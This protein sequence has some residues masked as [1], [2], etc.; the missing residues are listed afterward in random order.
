MK[1]T[2]TLLLALFISL[3]MLS[4]DIK[5]DIKDNQKL[6]LTYSGKLGAKK[7]FQAY[8]IKNLDNKKFELFS[9][10]INDGNVISLEKIIFD[11][12][13]S[14]ISY[15]LNNNTISML[16]KEER[17]GSGQNLRVLDINTKT[18]EY[19]IKEM[20]RFDPEKTILTLKDKTIIFY[21]ENMKLFFNLIIDSQ[22]ITNKYLEIDKDTRKTFFNEEHITAIN[23]DDFVKNGS[24]QNN[25]L[26]FNNNTIYFTNLN[27]K[28]K[29]TSV[30]C[31]NFDNL[32][33]FKTIIIKN[34]AFENIKD[35][36]SYIF[37]DNIITV[38]CSKNDAEIKITNLNNKKTNFRIFLRKDLSKLLDSKMLYNFIKTSVK[39]KFK[40]TVTVNL[41]VDN[42][43]V[44]NLDFIEKTQYY[45]NNN[46][47]LHWMMQHQMM[48]HQMM[49]QQQMMQR[50]FGP[51]AQEFYLPLFK[52]KENTLIQ[53]VISNDYKI[54]K[55]ASTK[56]KYKNIDIESYMED[57][58]E[59]KSK[60][61]LTALF[62]DDNY[63]IIYYKRNIKT[64]FL[65]KL[66]YDL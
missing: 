10:F 13:I 21:K 3:N 56:T 32:E 43:L 49:I 61:L 27:K 40:P 45:Y 53:F 62:N 18:Q 6:V 7:G 46:W 17:R 26:Y 5:I 4:N 14:I 23:S 52:E 50:N 29:T 58:K 30:L 55:N 59:D 57:Y 25:T 42:N 60:R 12:K 64:V 9:Y 22:N 37:E 36:N 11:H 47:N 24:A 28:R 34:D 41:S 15:H 33:S 2:I 20:G 31:V 66:N 19:S 35:F 38:T 63:Y 44:V 1:T 8:L 51:S 48:Q 16:I 65:K 39:T 54:L